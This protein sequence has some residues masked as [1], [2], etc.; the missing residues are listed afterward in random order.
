MV[1]DCGDDRDGPGGRLR[2][3]GVLA[4]REARGHVLRRRDARQLTSRCATRSSS[5]S[6]SRCPSRRFTAG[7]GSGDGRSARGH[8]TAWSR[9]LSRAGRPSSRRWGRL[10]APIL[11]WAPSCRWV[12]YDALGPTLGN[13]A[14]ASIM[15]GAAMQ[16]SMRYPDEVRAA[17][18]EGDGMEL[19][20]NLFDKLVSSP[21]GMVY[22]VSEYA[23]TWDR[24]AHPDGKIHLYI[25]ELGRRVPVAGQRGACCRAGTASRFVPVGRRAP[26]VQRQRRNP[27]PRVAQEGQGRLAADQPRR[28]HRPR[29]WWTATV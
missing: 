16:A 27:R 1:I 7:W 10:R 29:P 15:F 21:S 22:S 25:E 9:R 19:A 23:Q 8:R 6:A 14:P 26:F 20:S 4:V 13:M 5:R 11:T 12:L 3:A 28:R 2:A 17:G 24:I 18:I